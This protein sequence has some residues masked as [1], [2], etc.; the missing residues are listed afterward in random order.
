MTRTRRWCTLLLG[1]LLALIVAHPAWASE[2]TTAQEM[3]T[4]AKSFRDELRNSHESRASD[5][6]R[7]A[8]IL[9]AAFQVYFDRVNE[10]GATDE[11]KRKIL[12]DA[13]KVLMMVERDMSVSNMVLQEGRRLLG[14]MREAMKSVLPASD[15]GPEDSDLGY[16]KQVVANLLA[17]ARDRLEDMRQEIKDVANPS[18]ELEALLADVNVLKDLLDAM[19]SMLQSNARRYPMRGAFRNARDKAKQIAGQMSTG[20]FGNAIDLRWNDLQNAITNLGNALKPQIELQSAS[21]PMENE[22]LVRKA[23][24]VI[25]MIQI[26]VQALDALTSAEAAEDAK[27]LR[28][29]LNQLGRSLRALRDLAAEDESRAS[30]RKAYEDAQGDMRAASDLLDSIAGHNPL[31]GNL[32]LAPVDER[33]E[34][35]HRELP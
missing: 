17:I 3:L 1:F 6:L 13:N 12:H 23:D 34:A 8:E 31:L 32:T 26:Q 16:D 35:L 33:M 2:A 15:G 29:K 19:K 5:M 30:I 4:R 27:S 22:A 24:Q 21:E 18:N 20:N 28:P 9:V 7:N 25:D 14:E 11:Q 10:A